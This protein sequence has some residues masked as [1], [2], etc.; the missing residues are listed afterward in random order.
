MA[1]NLTDI[2]FNLKKRAEKYKLR[3]IIILVTEEDNA[4]F[5]WLLRNKDKLYELGYRTINFEQSY[6]TT[7][8]FV[9]LGGKC[10]REAY[11]KFI[12]TSFSN[13]THF[14]QVWHALGIKNF[15]FV[16]G[17]TSAV[18]QVSQDKR[19]S[20]QFVDIKFATIMKHHSKVGDLKLSRE[21]RFSDKISYSSDQFNGGSIT[22]LGNNHAKVYEKIKSINPICAD[23]S[24]FITMEKYC[25]LENQNASSFSLLNEI[26]Q[27]RRLNY[28]KNT[29]NRKK[30]LASYLPA[31][32]YL[33]VDFS[34]PKQTEMLDKLI[35]KKIMTPVMQTSSELIATSTSTDQQSNSTATT[36]ATGVMPNTNVTPTQL[37]PKFDSTKLLSQA[38]EQ[39]KSIPSNQNLS[40]DLITVTF[41]YP[42]NCDEVDVSIVLNV[43]SNDKPNVKPPI[44]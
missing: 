13:E 38:R 36:A 8:E 4:A 28:G 26:N 7:L 16:D 27:D 41:S 40:E 3:P 43:N 24:L 25:L 29:S 19:W 10:A 44:S 22:I 9:T 17:C 11:K 6:D 18:E 31:G 15:H 39:E 5:D 30:Y 20:F 23:A 35:L 33:P 42:K 32:K 21:K 37:D 34:D 12:E 14:S 1:A 2:Q